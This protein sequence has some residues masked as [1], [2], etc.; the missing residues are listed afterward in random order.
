MSKCETC[1]LHGPELPTSA[2]AA[3]DLHRALHELG[4]ELAAALRLK[5]LVRWLSQKLERTP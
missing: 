2:A 3:R 5:L 1:D 4:R